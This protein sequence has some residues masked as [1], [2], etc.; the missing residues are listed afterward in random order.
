MPQRILKAK[1]ALG[2]ICI[3]LTNKK[4]NLGRNLF[5]PFIKIKLFLSKKLWKIYKI[6]AKEGRSGE[7]NGEK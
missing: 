5:K 2:V 1:Q 4:P 6:S 3:F 7:K